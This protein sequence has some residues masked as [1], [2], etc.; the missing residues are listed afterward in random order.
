[1]SSSNAASRRKRR[2]SKNTISTVTTD[3]DNDDDPD[4]AATSNAAEQQR[5][6]EKKRIQ[7]R[8][9]Q[10]SCREKQASYVRQLERFVENI[11]AASESGTDS[12]SYV[13][14]LQTRLWDCMK[15]NQELREAILQMRKKMLSLSVA[16]S[17]G[18][19]ARATSLPS[20]AGSFI[21]SIFAK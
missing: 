1:M 4:H 2:E 18:A 7:N 16:A 10:Q 20:Q 14:Q 13:Q 11:Q 12:P 3:N 15:E 6:R 21:P 9:S 5:R 8:L 19:G 17:S